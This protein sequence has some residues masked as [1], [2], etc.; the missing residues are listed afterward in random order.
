MACNACNS[1]NNNTVHGSTFP[2]FVANSCCNPCC[3]NVA[4]VSTCGCDSCGA[5]GCNNC[6]CNSCGCNTC[7]CNACLLRTRGCTSCDND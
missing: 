7:G 4:G 3:G 6:G 2:D 1:G 5:C